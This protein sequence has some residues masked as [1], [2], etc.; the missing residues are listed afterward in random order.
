[1]FLDSEAAREHPG[2]G[3]KMAEGI[4]FRVV[5]HFPGRQG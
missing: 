3:C 1:M 2:R 5:A 4:R